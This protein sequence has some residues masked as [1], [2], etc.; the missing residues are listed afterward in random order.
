MFILLPSSMFFSYCKIDAFCHLFN[1]AFMYVRM[2]FQS[3]D[4]CCFMFL[5]AVVSGVSF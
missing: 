5:E 3:L 1:K 4:T 2:Y